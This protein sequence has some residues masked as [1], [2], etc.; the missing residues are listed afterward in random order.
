MSITSDLGVN[1][2]LIFVDTV[3]RWD[4][5][6]YVSEPHEEKMRIALNI[7]KALQSQGETVEFI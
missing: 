4:D 7:K 5:N 2:L 1:S 3:G 6:P